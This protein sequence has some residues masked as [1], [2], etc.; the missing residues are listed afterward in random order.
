MVLCVSVCDWQYSLTNKNIMTS[1]ASCVNAISTVFFFII[2]HGYW[3]RKDKV[4]L[5]RIKTKSYCS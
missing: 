3:Q 2:L 5:N 1:R 4:S